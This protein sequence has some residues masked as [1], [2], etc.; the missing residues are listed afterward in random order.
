[1]VIRDAARVL[2][3]GGVRAFR[4]GSD[5]AV[6][7]QWAYG[8]PVLVEAVSVPILSMLK[9]E[10]AR[11]GYSALRSCKVP[12]WPTRYMFW[13]FVVGSVGCMQPAGSSVLVLC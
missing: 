12:R 3:P 11:T 7:C 1:M 9:L 6:E 5:M 13:G 10:A 4:V 2:G 8:T